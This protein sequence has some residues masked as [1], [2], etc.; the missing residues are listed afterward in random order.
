[1]STPAT[2]RRMP[3]F[4]VATIAAI[5]ADFPVE[6]FLPAGSPANAVQLDRDVNAVQSMVNVGGLVLSRHRDGGAQLL[7]NGHWYN[8]TKVFGLRRYLAVTFTPHATGL[9]ITV[10]TQRNGDNATYSNF[11]RLVVLPSENVLICTNCGFAILYTE[12]GSIHRI[13]MNVDLV[14]GTVIL[15]ESGSDVYHFVD[16]LTKEYTEAVLPQ[17]SKVSVRRGKLIM[18]E[19]LDDDATVVEGT[20]YG[21]QEQISLAGHVLCRFTA[22]GIEFDRIGEFYGKDLPTINITGHLEIVLMDFFIVVR[23][24]QAITVELAAGNRWRITRDIDAQELPDGF[25]SVFSIG[26][27]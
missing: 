6:Q 5:H 24:N 9:N 27:R 14:C 7:P 4:N 18:L 12:D 21:E 20:P 17:G 16:R 19:P 8:L 10:R 1:M 25:V 3:D 13:D 11:R 22:G 2:I 23:H 26:S 15:N